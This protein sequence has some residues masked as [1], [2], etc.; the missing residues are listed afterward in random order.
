MGIAKEHGQFWPTGVM[1]AIT[2][3]VVFVLIL[4]VVVGMLGV[5]CWRGLN[6][7]FVLSFF[8]SLG[9]VLVGAAG[10]GCGDVIRGALLGEE[11]LGGTRRQMA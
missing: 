11:L 9:V 3:L 5:A 6:S 2:V 4:M 8:F 7:I 10:I 1:P